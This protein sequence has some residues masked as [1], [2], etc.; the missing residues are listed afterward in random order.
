MK[1]SKQDARDALRSWLRTPAI[2]AIAVTALTLGMGANVA[3]FSVIHAVL[4][5]PPPAP[6]P[7]R[8][9]LLRETIRRA[10]LGHVGEVAER[11]SG[12]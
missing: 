9:M 5:R 7:E 12:F 1:A 8:L 3:I 2:P 11:S 10:W 4:L 6:E